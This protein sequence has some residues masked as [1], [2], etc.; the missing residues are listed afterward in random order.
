MVVSQRK[1]D[2]W[3]SIL[4]VIVVIQHSLAYPRRSFVKYQEK[5]LMDLWT[6]KKKNQGI[7]LV[8][9]K[10]IAKTNHERS[11]GLKYIHLFGQS[12][13]FASYG[14]CYPSHNTRP[15]PRKSCL[16]EV[17]F[18]AN[19]LLLSCICVNGPPPF[20]IF[21]SYLEDCQDVYLKH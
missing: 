10:N 12:I 6:C 9:W 19:T 1:I 7:P 20:R 21:I 15:C 3:K 11:Q 14:E 16:E 18:G 8:E 2:I 13:V 4:V 5:M 17:C